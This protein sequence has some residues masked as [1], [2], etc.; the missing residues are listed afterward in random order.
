MDIVCQNFISAENMKLPLHVTEVTC[1]A[2][3]D[4]GRWLATVEYWNDGVITPEIRLK[5]WMFDD[6]KQT[7]VLRDFF[8][9]LPLIL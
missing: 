6:Q 3:H 2:F 1:A 5:F 8:I 7:Y 9:R 4:D